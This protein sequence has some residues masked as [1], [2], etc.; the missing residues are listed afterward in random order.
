[1]LTSNPHVSGRK[2]VLSAKGAKAPPGRVPGSVATDGAEAEA[3]G[4]RS[5]E[6]TLDLLTGCTASGKESVALLLAERLDAEIISVDSVKVYIG[7]DIG[8]A[9]PS[10]EERHRIPH[11]LINVAPPHETFTLARYLDAA[12]KAEG[13]VRARG[14]RPI[15]S[16]GTP[17][18]A[19]GLLFGVFEGPPADRALRDALTSRAD[20]EGNASLHSELRTLDPE[21]A[22]RIH[23]NDRKRVIRAIEVARLTGRP[24]SEHQTQ[25]Q[26]APRPARI[27]ALRRGREDLRKRIEARVDRMLEAGLV[28]EVREMRDR[29][30]P[31]ASSAVG[32]KEVLEYLQGRCSLQEARE[33]ICL[34]T[35]RLSRKQMTWFRHL[36]RLRW[37]DVEPDEPA[38]RVADRAQALW[39][40]E[41]PWLREGG[42]A[43]R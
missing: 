38:E 43:D 2:R 40:A 12:A 13:E 33:R 41:T 16:G 21:A 22:A 37:V 4:T 17:L 28:E 27:V 29:L 25:T 30:G 5:G 26:A 10:A 14:K 42:A 34:R 3:P 15:Y 8:S 7:L 20:R 6:T 11:H 31:T 1:M 19:R 32:Y 24:I 18:Y 23:P 9:K 39:R 36:G 35:W